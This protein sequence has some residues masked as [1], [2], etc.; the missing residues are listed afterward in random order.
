MAESLTRIEQEKARM[1]VPGLHSQILFRED[2]AE[3]SMF[4]LQH[5]HFDD[6]K[7]RSPAKTENK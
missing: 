5:G 4:F 7:N 6:A 2:V 3:Q 1:V